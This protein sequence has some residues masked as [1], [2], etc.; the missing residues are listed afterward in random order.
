MELTR[1]F[2]N[3]TD[4]VYVF[5]EYYIDRVPFSEVGFWFFNFWI[6]GSFVSIIYFISILVQ[7]RIRLITGLL[8]KS[9]KTEL[10]SGSLNYAE[11][12]LMV[13]QPHLPK[14]SL[15][16]T[17]FNFFS[18]FLMGWLSILYFLFL[19]ITRRYQSAAFKEIDLV[20]SK[21]IDLITTFIASSIFILLVILLILL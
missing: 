6:W 13:R 14:F 15:S 19:L 4:K 17:Y 1:S 12:L 20:I 21:K 3:Q 8:T 5:I 11:A 9:E 2:L 7:Y 10:N 18:F 16:L